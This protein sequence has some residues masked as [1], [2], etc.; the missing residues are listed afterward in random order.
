MV[1]VSR[2]AVLRRCASIRDVAVAALGPHTQHLARGYNTG[3]Q[4]CQ[5]HSTAPSPAA[6]TDAGPGKAQSAAHEEQRCAIPM[7]GPIPFPFNNFT[8]CFTLFSKC[9]SSFLH[10]TCSLS[11]S[12]QY[13][14]LDGIYHPLRAAFPNNSTRQRGVQSM[15]RHRTGLSPSVAPCSKGLR[16]PPPANSPTCNLQLAALPLRFQI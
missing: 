12:R 11:V 5:P 4:A 7:S 6:E 13:L 16:R 9:F 3:A 14:A 8:C 15:G 2:R 1:H 10:S